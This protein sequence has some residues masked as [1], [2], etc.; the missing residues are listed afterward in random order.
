MRS[1]AEAVTPP[2][3][4]A[5]QEA[6][7]IFRAVAALADFPVAAAN[8]SQDLAAEL[9]P[10]LVREDSQVA[11]AFRAAEDFRVAIGDS[12]AGNASLAAAGAIIAA[13]D[14]TAAAMAAT[15]AAFIQVT[16]TDSATTAALTAIPMATMTSGAIGFP[17]AVPIPTTAVATMAATKIGA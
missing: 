17:A 4:G 3:A 9:D 7:D 5:R 10:F 14:I 6:V 1:A 16:A 8:T 2:A 15:T 11:R 12:L 13:V